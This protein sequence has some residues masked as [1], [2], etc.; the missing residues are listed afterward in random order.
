MVQLVSSFFWKEASESVLGP[1]NAKVSTAAKSLPES[2]H[3]LPREQKPFSPELDLLQI[4]PHSGF[5]SIFGLCDLLYKCPWTKMALLECEIVFLGLFFL[6]LFVLINSVVSQFHV[7]MI[8]HK[9]AQS[10]IQQEWV[11][12]VCTDTYTQTCV[13]TQAHI[14]CENIIHSNLEKC[15]LDKQ[16]TGWELYILS[17]KTSDTND[18]LSRG[19]LL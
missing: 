16:E 15:A 9:N 12:C 7:M 3:S 14:L 18:L 5:C 8:V 11:T 4:S 17:L 6:I 19:W 2:Q 10:S 1:A 13:H